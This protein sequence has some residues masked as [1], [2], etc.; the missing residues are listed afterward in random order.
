MGEMTNPIQ[1]ETVLNWE[2]NKEDLND[3][4]GKDYFYLNI[5]ESNLDTSIINYKRCMETLKDWYYVSGMVHGSHY[6][7]DL[8]AA[9]VQYEK[10]WMESAYQYATKIEKDSMKTVNYLV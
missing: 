3:D 5:P 1:A 4:T 8:E 2:Q 6:R 9:K 7:N 10:A